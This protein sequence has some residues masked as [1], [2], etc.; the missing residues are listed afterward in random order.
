V[1]E[2]TAAAVAAAQAAGRSCW[3]VSSTLFS[4]VASDV[5]LQP[6]GPFATAAATAAAADGDGDAAAQQYPPIKAGQ[7]VGRKRGICRRFP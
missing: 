5:V 4:H 1:T 7:Q 2:A 3:R 6:L